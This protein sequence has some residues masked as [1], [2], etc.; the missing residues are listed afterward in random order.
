MEGFHFRS[1]KGA[2]ILKGG[3][4]LRGNLR[5]ILIYEHMS[6]GFFKSKNIRCREF[7]CFLEI[8]IEKLKL[9]NFFIK[10]RN[11]LLNEI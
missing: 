4:G 10:H 6:F 5:Y 8:I 9:K 2:Y 11:L 3:G 7:L 1:E